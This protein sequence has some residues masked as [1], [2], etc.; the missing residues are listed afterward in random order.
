MA[1]VLDAIGLTWV[2]GVILIGT[3]VYYAK[4]LLRPK[5]FGLNIPPFPVPKR[6]V[7]GHLHAW[8]RNPDM[9]KI[10]EYREKVGDIFSLDLAGRFIVVVNGY[11]NLKEVLVSHWSEA[12][13]RPS[14]SMH[15]LLNETNSG[16]LNSH[17]DN[18]K[19]QRSTAIVILRN[20]GMGKNVMAERITEEV[21]IFTKKLASYNSE[22]VDF[23]TLINISIS[24][25]ICSMIV[26]KRFDYDDPYFVKLIQNLNSF[27]AKAPNWTALSF[28]P[29]L[30]YL[31][32]DAFGIKSWI[33]H[34]LAVRNDFSVH[35]INEQKKTFNKDEEPEN[36]ITS[37]LQKMEKERAEGLTNYLDEGNLTATLRA[38]FLAGSETTSTT[39]YWCVLFCLHYPEVQE[40]VFKEMQIH[41]GEGRLPNINNR[42]HLKYLEAVIRETQRFAGL[43]P[44]MARHATETFELN[45]Y[46]IP[47]DTM[48]LLNFSS[49][50]HDPKPWEDP[51][52]FRPERFLDAD[53]NLTTNPEEF[54][55]FGLGRRICLGEALAKMELF[56]CLSAMFQRFRFEPEDL[57]RELPPMDGKVQ[58]V[59]VPEPY[60]VK[61]VP[62]S[63]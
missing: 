3:L 52:K 50:L 18:W 49:A 30:P 63:H 33:G 40:K 23:R 54:M 48:L 8:G 6:F 34:A 4:S 17:G 22:P 31:P 32:F 10:K 44:I 29:F 60:K 37:Y 28:F 43:V 13:N 24:N 35:H 9:K 56:L 27:F 47:K 19:T 26:G 15:K 46:T 59:L 16:I 2:L 38:L 14:S 11:E 53:G 20:L 45:G 5:Y 36:F 62:R 61:F 41:V 39:I 55:P 58:V 51:E 42:P 1:G 12:A 57:S 21:D 7:T 25:I